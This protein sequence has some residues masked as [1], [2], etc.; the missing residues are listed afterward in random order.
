VTYEENIILPWTYSGFFQGTLK[1]FPWRNQKAL[2]F[3]FTYSKLRKQP[4]LL[5]IQ[6][7]Q[8]AK[9][10]KAYPPTSMH[11][12]IIYNISC[13]EHTRFQGQIICFQFVKQVQVHSMFTAQS[14]SQITCVSC[15]KWRSVSHAS[16]LWRINRKEAQ[17]TYHAI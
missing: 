1:I 8:N 6:K 14:T 3:N 7:F 13:Y 2:K 4:F 9:A 11:I 16:H 5:K 12:I 15:N 17:N 10:V